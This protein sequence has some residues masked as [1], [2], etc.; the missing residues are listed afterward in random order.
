M[1]TI[2]K[3]KL[4]FEFKHWD[5]LLFEEHTDYDL[6]G[7]I[8]AVALKSLDGKI[9]NFYRQGDTENAQDFSYTAYSKLFKSLVDYFEVQTTR[10]R[11]HRQLPG[12]KTPLHTDDNN[13]GIKEASEYNLRLLT[14]LTES[15]KFLYQ[16]E[17]QGKLEQINLKAGE[18]VIFDPDTVSHGMINNSKNKIRYSLI[19]VFKA[20][21]VTNWLTDFINKEQI[22]KL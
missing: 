1:L 22:I 5:K 15:D 2:A 7:C 4:D 10:I 16:F 11:I 18:S 6:A 20:Y 21:P 19:Q 14:A 12:K 8:D 13:K 3:T 17:Y 9:H